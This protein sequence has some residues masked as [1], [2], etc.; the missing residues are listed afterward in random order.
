MVYGH[1]YPMKG[2]PSGKDPQ[3]CP[4]TQPTPAQSPAGYLTTCT[5]TNSFQRVTYIL[6]KL[7]NLSVPQLVCVTRE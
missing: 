7:H 4:H 1:P 3:D 2:N 6:G 5:L